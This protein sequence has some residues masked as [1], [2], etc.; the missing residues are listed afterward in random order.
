IRRPRRDGA[1]R[2]R[3]LPAPG[4]PACP[5]RRHGGRRVQPDR[6]A[7][8]DDGRRRRQHREVGGPGMTATATTTDLRAAPPVVRKLVEWLETTRIPDGLFT[9]DVFVDLTPPQWRIQ[10]QGVHD[11]LAIR[12][13][14]HPSPGR[15]TRLRYDPTPTGFVLEWE[16]EWDGNGD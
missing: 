4:P 16:E 2:R 5:H 13:N 11:T 12:N 14:G 1:C 7:A 8:A 6:Q 10:A 15:V 3:V 9:D